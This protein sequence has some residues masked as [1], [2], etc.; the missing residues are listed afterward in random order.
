M[1]EEFE[2][3]TSMG[4][5][6]GQD[7]Q[8]AKPKRTARP[9]PSKGASPLP[10]TSVEAV[11][12]AVY[13]IDSSGA[14]DGLEKAMLKADEVGTVYLYENGVFAG[15]LLSPEAYKSFVKSK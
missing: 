7:A 5:Q 4:A 1:N 3:N 8:P 6:A 10:L 12:Q 14:V 2:Q 9:R 11:M 15:A 13:N